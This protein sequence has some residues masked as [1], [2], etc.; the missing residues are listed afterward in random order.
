MR[1][2]I[3]KELQ[4]SHKLLVT[5]NS[6]YAFQWKFVDTSGIKPQPDADYNFVDARFLLDYHKITELLMGSKLYRDPLFAIREC[7]QNS[8]DA[9]HTYNLKYP[10]QESYIVLS[11][12][13]QDGRAFLDI[14]DSGTGMDQVM[15]IE[16]LLAI[17]SKSFYASERRYKEWG[18]GPLSPIASHGIG[19]LS[20]FMLADLVEV[21]SSYLRQPPV[22]LKIDSITAAIEFLNT[23]TKNFPSW[24]NNLLPWEHGTCVRL[25]LKDELPEITLMTFLAHNILRVGIPLKVVYRNQIVDLNEVWHKTGHTRHDN[26][27][28]E[29]L[30][31]FLFNPP[32][33]DRYY[34]PPD[35]G[36]LESG[37]IQDGNIKFKV[38]LRYDDAERSRI[39]QNGIL[40]SDGERD[41]DFLLRGTE[42]IQ[43]FLDHYPFSYDI[44]LVGKD[45]F[46]LDAERCRIIYS[47]KNKKIALDIEE[48]LWKVAIDCI[49]KIESSLYF[50][51]GAK[52][53]HG[54]GDLFAKD[55]LMQIY[56]HKALTEW[57]TQQR[58]RE[59]HKKYSLEPVLK[60]KIYNLCSVPHNTPISAYDIL[61]KHFP[62]LIPLMP[63]C[64]MPI[65]RKS[66]RRENIMEQMCQ[67]MQQQVLTSAKQPISIDQIAFLPGFPDICFS[68]ILSIICDFEF[69]NLN[70]VALLAKPSPCSR[71]RF[72]T[73]DVLKDKYEQYA[74]K[75]KKKKY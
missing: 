36:G 12:H 61:E 32:P 3:E 29:Q 22:H 45:C 13:T 1:W 24:K 43:T 54:S 70:D 11:Y 75:S 9:I 19:F 66:S 25:R 56:F 4:L 67:W 52:Y 10:D 47:S 26:A 20:T 7:I 44:N 2:D 69:E 73:K 38:Q 18:S 21:F 49:S 5:G 71:Y 30:K 33:R 23:D 31:Q 65:K 35:D 16:H 74:T 57:F 17:G 39:S 72:R 50:P 8:L 58:I 28:L 55:D 41:F 37:L 60:A 15:C 59:F 68:L 62:I 6:N 27:D 46:E 63:N 51:N 42:R 34:N 14:F 53:Y 40:I 48:K 64:G